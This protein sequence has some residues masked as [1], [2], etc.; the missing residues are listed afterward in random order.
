M[1]ALFH[2]RGAQEEIDDDVPI[3]GA[4]VTNWIELVMGAFMALITAL[5]LIRSL[6]EWF[7]LG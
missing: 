3:P 6:V 2:Q 5:S 4:G 1:P 7:H